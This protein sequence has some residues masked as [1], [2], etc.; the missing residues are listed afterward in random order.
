[1]HQVLAANSRYGRWM[2]SRCIVVLASLFSLLLASTAYAA[3]PRPGILLTG[4]IQFP[5]AQAMSISTDN[6]DATRLTV[7]L[8]F[9]GRCSGGGIGESWA[10]NVPAKPVLRAAGGRVSATLTGSVKRL[11]GVDGRVGNF[12]WRLNGRFVQDDVF[13]GTVDGTAAVVVNGKTVSRCRIASPAS[14]RLT[15]RGA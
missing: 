15:V 5:R 8:G 4:K 9:D 11:G 10:A 3:G 13:T 7:S 2:G 12:R 1:M 14:V 6:K